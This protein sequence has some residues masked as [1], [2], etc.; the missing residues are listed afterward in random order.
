MQCNKDISKIQSSLSCD[1][2]SFMYEIESE[3]AGKELQ[4]IA[5]LRETMEKEL[6]L[7]GLVL[8]KLDAQTKEINLYRE[9]RDEECTELNNIVLVKNLWWKG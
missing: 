1:R 7:V 9:R 8:K 2:E 5:P 6:E 3:R 4:D